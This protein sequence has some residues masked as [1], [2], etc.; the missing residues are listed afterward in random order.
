MSL[1]GLYRACLYQIH[2]NEMGLGARVVAVAVM[3]RTGAEAG[4]WLLHLIGVCDG[5]LSKGL[6]DAQRNK[7]GP[8]LCQSHWGCDGGGLCLPQ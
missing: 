1:E 4:L 2:G 7:A 6:S 8:C 5:H 3:L